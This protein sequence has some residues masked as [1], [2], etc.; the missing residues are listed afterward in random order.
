M[1]SDMSALEQLRMLAAVWQETR[2]HPLPHLTASLAGDAVAEA[3]SWPGR[4]PREMRQAQLRRVIESGSPLR[5]LLLLEDATVLR[6]AQARRDDVHAAMHG[7][8]R[9]RDA[10]RAAGAARRSTARRFG[11]QSI[12]VL[13]V[14]L[15]A[16]MLLV[17]MLP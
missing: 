17:Q 3:A 5:L 14:A 9:R 12:E 10:L 1:P 6:A 8:V 13:G 11:R 2:G 7:L 4:E 16:I 15:S